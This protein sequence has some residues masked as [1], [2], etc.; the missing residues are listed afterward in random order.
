MDNRML[1][2]L[3]LMG[4]ES[5]EETDAL[6]EWI[7]EDPRNAEAFALLVYQDVCLHSVADKYCRP[8]EEQADL[9]EELAAIEEASAPTQVVDLTYQV[10]A[11]R[12]LEQQQSLEAKRRAHV[13]SYKPR[14]P[15]VLVIPRTIVWIGL[16]AAIAIAATLLLELSGPDD[17][18]A[19]LTETP[20][21]SEYEPV[22][23]PALA[24]LVRSLDAR[25]RAGGDET[26]YLRKG[27]HTLSEGLVEL[28]LLNGTQVIIEAP[29]T[30]ELTGIN[31]MGV[32][33]GRAVLTVPR[34]STGFIVETPTARLIESGNQFSLNRQEQPFQCDIGNTCARLVLVNNIKGDQNTE[35]GVHVDRNRQTHIQVFAG[36]VTA[37]SITEGEA[38]GEP[39]PLLEAQSAVIAKG[40]APQLVPFDELAF[41]REITTR[42]SLADMVMGGNGKTQRQDMGLHPLTGQYIRQI[43]GNSSFV[44]LVSTGRAQPVPGSE[45]VARAFIPSQDGRLGGLPAGLS[46]PNLPE[47]NGTGYG[48]IWSGDEMPNIV[49]DDHG[50]VPTAL[51]GYNF[52][53]AGQ[54]AMVMHTNSGFIV[55]LDAVR[56]TY[57][58]FEIVRVQA[59]AGNSSGRVEAG[60]VSDSRSEF[61]VYRDSELA[62][63]STFIRSA[64]DN[65]R[66][67]TIDLS[68]HASDRYLTFAS[69]DGGDGNH[70]DWIVLGNPLIVLK[71]VSNT[72]LNF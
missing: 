1:C 70:Q 41:K 16:A 21:H 12:Q 15:R 25:W 9:L 29:A 49:P 39:I 6:S 8:V 4:E 11:Q 10:E 7:L 56:A 26:G 67:A 23:R 3:Y 46:L 57:P 63:H 19:I 68:L 18:P 32:L 31:S 48:V 53:G 61:Y 38:L 71:P 20:K 52:A 24:A 17:V 55:D 60:S 45:Y 22:V 47:T 72:N 66:I 51:P 69:T 14:K 33:D 58:G 42:L 64:P 62:M 44:G 40:S 35:F 43:K 27:S 36:Q 2:L 30:I 5:P 59:V 34:A 65:Q 28:K 50:T 13:E 54:Q 37:T